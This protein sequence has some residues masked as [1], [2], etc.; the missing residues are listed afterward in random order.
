MPDVC[1]L[2]SVVLVVLVLFIHGLKGV[3]NVHVCV[4]VRVCARMRIYADDVDRR[5]H[6]TI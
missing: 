2:V 4:R 3:G 1:Y 5:W 6:W